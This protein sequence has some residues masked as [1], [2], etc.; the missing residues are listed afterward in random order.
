MVLWGEN[1]LLLLD[2]YFH[3]LLMVLFSCTLLMGLCLRF[4]IALRAQWVM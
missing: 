1:L 3:M 2:N 4:R